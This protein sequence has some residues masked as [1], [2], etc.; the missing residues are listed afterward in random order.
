ML[1]IIVDTS[2]WSEALRRKGQSLESKN[3]FLNEIIQNE[4]KIILTGIILQEILTGIKNDILFSNI[5]NILKD[6][7]YI[8]AKKKDYID[9]AD[10][11]N[12]LSKKGVTAGSVDFLIAC[13]CINNNFLLASYDNDFRHISKNSE[14]Q[15]IDFEEY[16]KI[17]AGQS[18]T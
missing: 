10:L 7:A 16:K 3:I 4:D 15:V 12:K 18:L 1:K 6:F 13:I 14:L 17:K 2:V 5:K 9:A 8:E 11:K